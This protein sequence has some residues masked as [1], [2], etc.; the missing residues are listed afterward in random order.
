M[1][2]IKSI[3]SSILRNILEKAIDRIK[4]ADRRVEQVGEIEV[5]LNGAEHVVSAEKGSGGE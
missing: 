1:I 4:E 3:C 2:T 5:I